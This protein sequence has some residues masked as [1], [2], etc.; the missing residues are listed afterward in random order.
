MSP[1]APAGRWRTAFSLNHNKN[2]GI[3]FKMQSEAEESSGFITI[4]LLKLGSKLL[5]LGSN[6][7]RFHVV[8][9]RP[10]QVRVNP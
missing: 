6:R 9:P 2:P 3:I 8:S 7:D 5:E 10:R 1:L 4:F